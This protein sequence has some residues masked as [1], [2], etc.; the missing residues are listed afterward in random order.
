[1]YVL[2]FSFSF[3]FFFLR[4]LKGSISFFPQVPLETVAENV[5]GNLGSSK[6][7]NTSKRHYLRRVV[8]RKTSVYVYVY[9]YMPR[10][11]PLSHEIRASIF[12]FPFYIILESGPKNRVEDYLKEFSRIE[13]SIWKFHSFVEKNLQL[14]F[15]LG[16]VVLKKERGKELTELR[17]TH[18]AGFQVGK[19]KMAVTLLFHRI[20]R[21]KVNK[22]L[23]NSWS[24]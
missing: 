24:I 12:L 5:T 21:C 1:M 14:F 11:Q 15:L 18:G 16:N 17:N 6:I 3:L 2:W 13:E 22:L 8:S 23:E 7:V 20:V 19:D 9:I 10:F 4:Y